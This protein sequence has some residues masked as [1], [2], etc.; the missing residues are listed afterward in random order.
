MLYPQ[1]A[2]SIRQP[3]PNRIF[4]EGKDVENRDWPTRFR[5]MVLVHAGK[6]VDPEDRDEARDKN[7]PLGGIVGIMEIVDCV[8][9]MDSPWFFGEY[10]FVIKNARPLKFLPCRGALGFFKPQIDYSMLEAA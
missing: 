8:T 2:L 1:V 4:F 3:W 9:V 10:G 6:T 7:M 5:G